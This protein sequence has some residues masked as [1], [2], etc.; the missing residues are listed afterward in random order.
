MKRQRSVP[1]SLHTR[2]AASGDPPSPGGT[3]G[4]ASVEAS[5]A[6]PGRVA[7][8]GVASMLLSPVGAASLGP[9]SSENGGAGS[10]LEVFRHGA[11]THVWIEATPA[12]NE[13][14]CLMKTP[15]A[16]ENTRAF[17]PFPA[18]RPSFFHARAA[19]RDAWV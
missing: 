14:I 19:N 7:S 12:T 3:G 6:S 2:G 17:F 15:P 18:H 8:T 1:A 16:S 9:A 11:V 4:L 5:L 10:G 13:R